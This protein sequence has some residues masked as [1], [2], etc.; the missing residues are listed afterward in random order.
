V[1]GYI[2]G[3][4]GFSSNSVHGLGVYYLPPLVRSNKTFGGS[5][6]NTLHDDKI[7][8]IIPPVVGISNVT[9]Y[10]GAFLDGIQ[11]TYLLLGGTHYR[12][13][14]IGG[15][16]GSQSILQLYAGEVLY[17]LETAAF[18]DILGILSIYSRFNESGRVNGPY[19]INSTGSAETVSGNIL[20]LHG[21]SRFDETLKNH[22]VCRIGV[23]TVG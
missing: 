21:Y 14:F 18:G 13:N 22:L 9:L 8:S 23:Y 4:K 6:S 19:G 5:C 1:N 15:T 11:F 2:L 10:H 20:G 7:D 17:R 16:G 12:G 3:L